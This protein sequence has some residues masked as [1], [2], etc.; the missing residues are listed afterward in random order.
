MIPKIIHQT[1][2]RVDNLPSVY[3]KCQDKIRQL[4]PDWE[5][6]FWTDEMM[7]AEVEKSFPDIYPIFL[8]LPRKILQIDIFRY[9]L[10]WKYGGLYADLDYDFRR[11]FDL[12]DCNLVLPISRVETPIKKY[13]LRFGNCVF[14]SSPGHPFWKYILENVKTNLAR[15]EVSTDSDVMDSENGTGP[16]FVTDMYYTCP[17]EIRMQITTPERKLFHPLSSSKEKILEKNNCYG[18]HLCESIW[19]NN[20][21]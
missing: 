8:K 4:H 2:K 18:K 12:I 9:C 17:E 5:Y 14:A 13:P 21:L 15:L 20:K 1:Y 6:M 19:I 11:P 16:G 7:Y 3:K 10:M